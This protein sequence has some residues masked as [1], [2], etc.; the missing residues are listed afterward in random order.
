[1]ATFSTQI[2]PFLSDRR[3]GENAGVANDSTGVVKPAHPVGTTV[4]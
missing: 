2:D 1:M 4:T 3:F